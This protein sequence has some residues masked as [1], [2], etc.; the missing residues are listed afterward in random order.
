MLHRFHVTHEDGGEGEFLVNGDGTT[1][2]AHRLQGV[3]ATND[4][5]HEAFPAPREENGVVTIADLPCPMSRPDS[6]GLWVWWVDRKDAPS[7]VEVLDDNGGLAIRHA[8]TRDTPRPLAEWLG[9]HGTRR[10][11]VK[12]HRPH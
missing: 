9:Q 3:L 2:A 6:A 1:D 11:Y 12:V 5:V 10:P 4:K 8:H 7:L